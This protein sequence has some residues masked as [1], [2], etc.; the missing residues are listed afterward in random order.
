MKDYGFGC[1]GLGPHG[2]KPCSVNDTSK[3]AKP[4]PL[5][6]NCGCDPLTGAACPAFQEWCEE[7]QR[8]VARR[9]CIRAL[10]NVDE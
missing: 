7:Q 9:V 1:N 6:C 8:R 5:A 4:P 2:P 3:G 10:A